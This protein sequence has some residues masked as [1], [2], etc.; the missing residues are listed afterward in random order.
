[1]DLPFKVLVIIFSYLTPNDVIEASV[2]FKIFYYA[3]RKNKL[4]VKKLFDSRKLHKYSKWIFHYYEN[5]CCSFANQ[6]FVCLN[7]YD[8]NKENLYLAKEALMKKLYYS[9]LPFRV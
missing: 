9:I 1:M 8:V 5:V 7:K 2:V 4:F 6:L 3:F